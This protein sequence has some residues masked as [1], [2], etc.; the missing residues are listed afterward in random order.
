MCGK[1]ITLRISGPQVLSLLLR[2][3][4]SH[5]GGTLAS[6]RLSRAYRR[7]LRQ[8][9]LALVAWG[10]RSRCDIMQIDDPIVMDSYLERF[11][12]E[13]YAANGCF[14]DC[15]HA[16]LWVQYRRRHWRRSLPRAWDVMRSWE[17]QRPSHS[18]TPL[19]EMLL[20]AMWTWAWNY[21]VSHPHLW[22]TVL[23]FAFVCRLGFAGLLRP[24]ELCA[25]RIG[26]LLFT[27]DVV[28]SADALV[29]C[30]TQPKTRRS[31]ARRQFVMID[32]P[33]LGGMV[34]DGKDQRTQV[35]ATVSS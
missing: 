14:H 28:G 21:S 27:K 19:P 35:V 8:G 2:M 26:H 23:L 12:E 24:G 20:K 32:D 29:L 16:I 31:Y 15:K 18:R 13:S 9:K 10:K 30:L 22:S 25:L 3:V 17:F 1:R 6:A 11:V 5:D 34:H 4:T 7:R 33:A